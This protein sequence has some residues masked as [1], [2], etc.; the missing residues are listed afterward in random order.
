MEEKHEDN[1]LGEK[2]DLV[3]NVKK[4]EE[5]HEKNVWRST[6][7]KQGATIFFIK[8]AACDDATHV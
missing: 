4:M 1:K 6:S 7:P 5:K 3:K 2:S 8:R